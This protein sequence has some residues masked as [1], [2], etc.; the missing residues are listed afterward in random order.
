MHCYYYYYYYLRTCRE[1]WLWVGHSANKL[2]NSSVLLEKKKKRNWTQWLDNTF[3]YG[4]TS[5]LYPQQIF[6]PTTDATDNF[7]YPA[8]QRGLPKAKKFYRLLLQQFASL[9]A[10]K[11]IYSNGLLY[12]AR[13]KRISSHYFIFIFI[14]FNINFKN[15]CYFRYDFLLTLFLFIC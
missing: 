1:R 3:I 6:I 11:G 2:N 9:K 13:N 4:V 14:Y 8:G 12:L 5:V 10:L 15:V 7:L